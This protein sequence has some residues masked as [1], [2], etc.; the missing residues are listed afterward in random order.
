[1]FHETPVSLWLTEPLRAAMNAVS[2]VLLCCPVFTAVKGALELTFGAAIVSRNA[3]LLSLILPVAAFCVV[4]AYNLHVKAVLQRDACG[5]ACD[6]AAA[7]RRW[8]RPTAQ[9][10]Q[11]DLPPFAPLSGG[12]AT[13]TAGQ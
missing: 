6:C 5:L 9:S 8:M 13:Q 3:A 2:T 4:W 12:E 10:A 1:V 11:P 7:V